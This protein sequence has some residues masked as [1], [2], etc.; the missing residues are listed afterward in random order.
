[1]WP[2]SINY[3]YHYS[4][5]H[6]SR[7]RFVDFVVFIIIMV[8]QEGRLYPSVLLRVSLKYSKETKN[9]FAIPNYMQNHIST[10]MLG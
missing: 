9:Y 3:A 10:G 7:F 6:H 2:S 4:I 8:P 5:L 1:M